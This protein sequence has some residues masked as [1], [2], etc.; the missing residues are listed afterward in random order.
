MLWVCLTSAR[1]KDSFK[2][3][4]N[5]IELSTGKIH[6]ENLVF[7]RLGDK[8][9]FHQDNNLKHKAKYTLELITKTTLYVSLKYQY[10]LYTVVQVSYH[11]FSLQWSP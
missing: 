1:T 2:I 7:N 5:R 8:F 10:A 3:K 11:C 9:T 4:R 6:E